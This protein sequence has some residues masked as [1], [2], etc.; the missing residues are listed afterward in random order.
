MNALWHPPAACGPQRALAALSAAHLQPLFLLKPPELLVIHVMTFAAKQLMQAVIADAQTLFREAAQPFPYLRI[1]RPPP[2]R[3]HHRP[4]NAQ[5]IA[6]MPFADIRCGLKVGH[7][8]P[9]LK[10]HRADP[11][12]AANLRRRHP[13]L[14]FLRYR[15]NLLCAEPGAIHT[16]DSLKRQDSN[17]IWMK[18]R[19][20][21]QLDSRPMPP[22]RNHRI[23]TQR[24][25]ESPYWTRALISVWRRYVLFRS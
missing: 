16:S 11:V 5:H 14:L 20:S 23:T 24:N 19:G 13:G 8:L 2:R 18:L 9:L 7:R 3:A 17:Q 21:D 10:R 15:G 22:R 1:I 4:F 12:A 25:W 6:R